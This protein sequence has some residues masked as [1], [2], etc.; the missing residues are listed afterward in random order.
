MKI[1]TNM[2]VAICLG[3][4]LAMMSSHSTGRIATRATSRELNPAPPPP[5]FLAAAP[6]VTEPAVVACANPNLA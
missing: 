1:L 5:A 2:A 6:V 3:L 4:S